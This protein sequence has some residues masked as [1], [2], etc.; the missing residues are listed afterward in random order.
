MWDFIKNIIENNWG[1]I[2]TALLALIIRLIEKVK[3]KKQLMGKMKAE[4]PELAG[5]IEKI[6]NGKNV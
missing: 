1:V 3:N 5:R 2:S 6:I 4:F